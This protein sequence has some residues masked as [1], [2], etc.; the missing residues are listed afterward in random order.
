MALDHKILHLGALTGY[1]T[2]LLSNLC[3][4]IVAVEP[5]D[6]LRILFKNNI[7]KHKITNI[8]IVKESLK[9]SCFNEAPFDRIFIDNPIKKINDNLLKQLNDDLGKIVMIQKETN[10]LNKAFKITKNNN[11]F[12]KEYL[13]DVF[14]K[15]ELYEESEEFVF[16]KF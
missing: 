2:V 10:Q 7:N 8:R 11:N 5:N 16:W 4:E 9:K 3:A 14:T 1:V 6:E 15:Y 12:S 13:F